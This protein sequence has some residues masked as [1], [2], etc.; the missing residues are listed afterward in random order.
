MGKSEYKYVM[1]PRSDE[2]QRA[3][4]SRAWTEEELEAYAVR[5]MARFDC[6]EQRL[7]TVLQRKLEARAE[8]TNGVD[9]WAP[10]IDRLI[11]RFKRLGYLD[12]QRYALRLVES[13]RQKGAST[14]KIRE[15]LRTRGVES[16]LL[17]EL[18]VGA[19][20][21]SEHDFCRSRNVGQ[22]PQNGRT[23]QCSATAH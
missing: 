5:Y 16:G 21:N 20:A 18:L 17:A 11:D 19:N 13:L 15:R 1:P 23:S 22:A 10:A 7:R 2:R 8:S 9:T 4:A 3:R 14:R 12:D 6:T